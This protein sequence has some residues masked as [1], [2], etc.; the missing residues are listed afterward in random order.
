MKLLTFMIIF[1]YIAKFS[2]REIAK[3]SD[4]HSTIYEKS[5]N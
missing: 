4:L 2:V 1:H 3:L 5:Q